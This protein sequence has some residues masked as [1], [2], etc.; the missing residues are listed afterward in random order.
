MNV[1]AVFNPW[2]NK[3][4]GYYDLQV[5]L[6]GE[7]RANRQYPMQSF[8]KAGVNY[9][10]GTDLGAS[11]TYGSIECFHALTTRTYNNDDPDSLLNADE[12]LSREETLKAMTIGCAYQMR[13]E[14]SFGSIEAGKDASLCVFSKD[15]LTIPDAE[16]MSTQ[17]LKCMYKGSWFENAQQ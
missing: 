7:E 8:L 13:K 6:L 12:K 2:C 3:D 14:D 9:A 5:S 17:V 4:P 11:F 10:F 15:L 1:I 16:I